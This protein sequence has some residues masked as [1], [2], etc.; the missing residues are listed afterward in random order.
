M[1]GCVISPVSDA[2]QCF[3]ELPKQKRSLMDRS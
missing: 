1:D 2:A 3:H